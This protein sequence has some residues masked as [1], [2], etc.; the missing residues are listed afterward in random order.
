[1]YPAA[2]RPVCISFFLF[3]LNRRSGQ[4]KV[5]RKVRT[6]GVYHRVK[7]LGRRSGGISKAYNVDLQELA[8]INNTTTPPPRISAGSVVFIPDVPQVIDLPPVKPPVGT[9]PAAVKPPEKPVMA[10]AAPE[11]GPAAAE[12]ARAAP[13]ALSAGGTQQ[14]ERGEHYG[15]CAGLH[16]SGKKP[17]AG[18]TPGE[19][20]PQGCRDSRKKADPG[21]T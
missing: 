4:R 17:G 20:H 6:R 9:R 1:M 11:S 10:R 16:K 5:I 15:P 18:K 13:G 3:H 12:S 8:E 7:A 2:C 19:D 14:G 21:S